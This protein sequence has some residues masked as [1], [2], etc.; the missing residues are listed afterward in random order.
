MSLEEFDTEVQSSDSTEVS[1]SSEKPEAQKKGEYRFFGDGTVNDPPTK[2]VDEKKAIDINIV[3]DD[4]IVEKAAEMWTPNEKDDMIEAIQIVFNDGS[5]W[6]WPLREWDN[7]P[8]NVRQ[9]FIEDYAP[10]VIR[11]KAKKNGEDPQEAFKESMFYTETSEPE[12]VERLSDVG[13]SEETRRWFNKNADYLPD[14]LKKVSSSSDDVDLDVDGDDWT[15][16]W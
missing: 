11:W 10:E 4:S 16:D 13:L 15:E 2:E 1:N 3:T 5:T 14:L 7:D 9:H 12:W 6:H 8:A